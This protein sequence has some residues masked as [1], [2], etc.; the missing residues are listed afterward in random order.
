MIAQCAGK[1][2]LVPDSA[3][4]AFYIRI[5][6]QKA[7]A[8]CVYIYSAAAFYYLRISCYDR[9]AGFFRRPRRRLRYHIQKLRIGT[10]LNDI[11]RRY[12][13][14][15]RASRKQIVYR[16][17]YGKPPYIAA[18]KHKRRYNKA[19]GGDR[20][21]AAAV[22]YRAVLHHIEDRITACLFENGVYKLRRRSS[23]ATMRH[24]DLHIQAL[25]FTK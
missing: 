12:I 25:L 15:R 19:V 4:T 22:N 16:S 18:A 20:D 23:A 17:A 6:V 11:C 10:F 21:F 5:A 9:N 7:N 3:V 13:L 1:Y 2:Q 8:R 14:R 24:C